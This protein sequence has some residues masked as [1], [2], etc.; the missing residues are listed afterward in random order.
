MYS[1]TRNGERLRKLRK[2]AKRSIKET[3]ELLNT[4]EGAYGSYERGKRNPPDEIKERLAMLYG[5]TV[6]ALF[7]ED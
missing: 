2:I 3:A 5:M 7:F 1:V 6:Q 4:T